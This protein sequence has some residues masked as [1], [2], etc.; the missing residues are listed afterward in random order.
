MDQRLL[1]SGKGTPTKSC[2]PMP[3]AILERFMKATS[4]T[5]SG[6]APKAVP[7]LLIIVEKDLRQMD[8][9]DLDEDLD[10]GVSGRRV[11]VAARYCTSSGWRHC[12]REGKN[13][14]ELPSLLERPAELHRPAKER[15]Q[16]EEP[17]NRPPHIQ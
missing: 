4:M 9:V 11:A 8:Q 2:E 15:V 1:L 14:G 16:A 12:A 3:P 13:G 17:G 5:L 7:N 6:T 10:E